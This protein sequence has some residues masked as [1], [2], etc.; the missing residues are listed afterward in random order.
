MITGEYAVLDGALCFALPTKLGQK[1]TVKAH[2][3]TDLLWH[4][5][6]SNGNL[7][8][9]SEISIFDFSAVK[10]NNEEIS[11]KI[12]KYLKNA[13]RLNC[14]FLDKWNAFKI[15]THLEFPLDWGLGSSS[16]LIHLIAEWAEVTPLEL[17]FK[18]ENGSGYDVACAGAKGPIE[19]M[20]TDTEISYTPVDFKPSYSDK[21]HFVHLGS[22]KSSDEAIKEYISSVKDK[23]GLVKSI[24]EISE[25][26]QEASDIKSFDSLLK[27]HEEI[28]SKHTG[29]KKVKEERFS[30]FNG[31]VKSLG[32]W[33]GDFV[34]ATGEKDYVNKYFNDKGLKTILGYKDIIL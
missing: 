24:T 3:G 32:A 11:A 31:V 23:K 12:K 13:A 4:S 22:K 5:Y 1:M 2:R 27:G 30:D 18:S 8:F 14:E 34:L 6:D 17:Y 15:E 33:G 7:W 19:Y 16:T 25:N 26:I 9:E 29:F 21:I 10:T 28:I 20:S